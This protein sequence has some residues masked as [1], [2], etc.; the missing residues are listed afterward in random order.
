VKTVS[1]IGF[2]NCISKSFMKNLFL[3]VMVLASL[4]VL[5]GCSGSTDPAKWNS[6][7]IDSWFSKGEWLQGWNINPDSSIDKKELAM[8]YYRHKERWKMAFDFLKNNMLKDLEIKRYEIDGDNIFALVSE[9]PSK[10]EE[11]AKFEAHRQYID[12]QY[13]IKGEEMMGVSPLRNKNEILNPYD[14]MKDVEFM[15]VKNFTSYQASPN[16]FFIFFPSDIHR[17]GVKVERNSS[18]KKIVIKVK[19]N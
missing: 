17:P 4:T 3:I 6:E 8:S 10:N 1:T 19:V 5:T 11:D 18:V 14:T 16:R 13:V 12:I 7:Q 9:Y 15:T 2:N